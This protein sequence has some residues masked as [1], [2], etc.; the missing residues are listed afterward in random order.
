MKAKSIN[1]RKICIRTINL[2]IFYSH[3]LFADL[4][5]FLQ[6][7]LFAL[8][9]FF[10]NDLLHL[11]DGDFISELLDSFLDCVF[12]IFSFGNFVTVTEDG[13]FFRNLIEDL[14]RLAED[15]L[16]RVNFELS[17]VEKMVFLSPELD[18]FEF[19]LFGCMMWFGGSSVS[20]GSFGFI[21][22][23]A[24]LEF[25]AFEKRIELF[26]MRGFLGHLK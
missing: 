4:F 21:F 20:G 26:E 9:F 3:F 7:P 17:V 19:D 13:F 15:Q 12:D 8:F 1:Q 5:G 6:F 10:R 25:P 18:F 22:L 24:I 11:S 2:A 23:F 16:I 14:S